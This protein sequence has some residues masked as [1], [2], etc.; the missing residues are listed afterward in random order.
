MKQ[1]DV[2]SY[3][4]Y[5]TSGDGYYQDGTFM[6]HGNVVYN[7]GYGKEAFSNI[8]HFIYMLDNSP[9]EITGPLANIH[10]QEKR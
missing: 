7:G 4:G 5:V 3:M 2:P 8:S 6:Q 9:W 1:N 10:G